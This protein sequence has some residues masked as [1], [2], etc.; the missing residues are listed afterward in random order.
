MRHLLQVHLKGGLGLAYATKVYE[1][2]AEGEPYNNAI[3]Q[4]VCFTEQLGLNVVVFPFS[5]LGVQLGGCL[6]HFSNG[7]MSQPNDG[8]NVATAE[9]GLVYQLSAAPKIIAQPKPIVDKKMRFNAF[10]GSGI[11]QLDRERVYHYGLLTSS[12]YA[13]K[14]LSSI[15]AI[16]MGLDV[17]C[18]FAEKREADRQGL[19]FKR[20]GISVG[21]ELL[22][23]RLGVMVQ[24]GYH[25]YSPLPAIADFYQKLGFKYYLNEQWILAT[26]L[27]AFRF[28]ISDELTF[29][30][31]VRL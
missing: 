7:D 14:R 6:S 12:V 21:N 26:S 9:L 11:K 4:N 3:S 18:N 16:N 1:E 29:G 20:M 22:I 27:K 23:G 19:D 30:V 13:D 10:I 17:N 2:H 31:G 28:A 5:R 25:V 8:F 15:Y 24:G